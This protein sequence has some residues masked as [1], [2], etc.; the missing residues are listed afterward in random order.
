MA[1]ESVDFIDDLVITNPVSATDLVRYGA[2]HL[3][4]F[5]NGVRNSFAGTGGAI[6]CAGVD[7]GTVNAIVITPTPALIE[8]TTRMLI[9][10]HQS[11]TSTST[12]PTIN[13]SGLGA[14]TIVSVS[15]GA[16][17]AGDLVA[18]RVYVGVYDGTAGNVQLA[19]VTK[20]YVDQLAFASALPAQSLGWL[21]SDGA[22][23]SFTQTHTGY[24]QN[25]VKGAN[26]ASAATI[27]LTTATGNLV[28]ITGTTTI[29]AITIPVGAKRTVIFDGALTL[30]HSAA[31]LLP[32]G[33]NIVTTAGARAVVV[34]DT[35]G[36]N[37]ASY[38]D[39]ATTAE[40]KAGTSAAK[41]VTPVTLLAAQGYSN[42]FQSAD[43]TITSAGALTIA[44]GLTRAP[45]SVQ[46]FIKNTTAESGYSIGDITP[47][48]LGS[49]ESSQGAGITWD[50]TNIYVRF[51]SIPQVFA[52]TDKTTGGG[53]QT[54][55]TNWAFFVRAWA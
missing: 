6:L 17:A 3:R 49:A 15:G 1:T 31:L 46:A 47:A 40:V 35:A 26:I 20:N 11:I 53:S 48:K 34:G 28:H 38:T 43:Q 22:T 10:W 29:T 51:G 23:A 8:Y 14:K 52:I 45:I 13:V 12:T 21:R 9:V 44:H 4:N 30:T 7:V 27:N 5:K 32:G 37:V 33:A 39:P 19:A 50:A 24:A 54:T 18:N 36:A 2:S 42:Y 55:N 41:P 16:L 25:E